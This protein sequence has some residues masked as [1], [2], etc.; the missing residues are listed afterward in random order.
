LE[1]QTL[2]ASTGV[3]PAR[4]DVT[5]DEDTKRIL[6]KYLKRNAYFETPEDVFEGRPR[7]IEIYKKY[8]D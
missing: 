4:P 7:I 3:Q 5:P 6:P 2:L 8:F 1:G